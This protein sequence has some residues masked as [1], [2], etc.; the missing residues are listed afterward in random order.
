MNIKAVFQA[1]GFQRKV[2][3]LC[4]LGGIGKNQLAVAFLKEHGVMFSA[5]YW[6]NG[7]KEDALKQSFTSMARRLYKEH[8][9]SKRL[10]ESIVEDDSDQVVVHIRQWLSLEKNNQ[11]ILISTMLIVQNSLIPLTYIRMRLS[12]IFQTRI[13]GPS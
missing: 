4:G 6:M 12:H 2:V 11:C 1:S 5:I 13:T 10:K 9:S 3:T 7:K 8:S